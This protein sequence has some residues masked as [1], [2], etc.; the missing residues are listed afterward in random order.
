M[1]RRSKS[2]LAIIGLAALAGVLL[3]FN[4]RFSRLIRTQVVPPAGSAIT[5]TFTW[6]PAAGEAL[7]PRTLTLEATDDKGNKAT[8]QVT[9]NVL[10]ANPANAPWTRFDEPLPGARFRPG[11]GID[12][13]SHLRWRDADPFVCGDWSL[14]GK[15]LPPDFWLP[16]LGPT[17]ILSCKTGT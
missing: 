9:I 10:A 17:S 12:V 15:P 6:T 11:D 7:G 1:H 2:I 3:G 4:D 8:K 13:K 16:N 5:K 14:D